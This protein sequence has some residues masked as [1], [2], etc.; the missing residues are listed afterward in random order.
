MA[1]PNSTLL[2]ALRSLDPPARHLFFFM[3]HSE[4][5]V[6]AWDGLGDRVI[7]GVTYKGIGNAASISGVSRSK[8]LQTETVTVSLNGVPLS[9]LQV[10]DPNI[11]DKPAHITARWFAEDGTE[12]AS[13]VVFKGFGNYLT[14]NFGA[15]SV[16]LVAHL[17]GQMADWQRAPQ[18]FYTSA[19][20][21][22]LFAG[23]TGFDRVKTLQNTVVSGWGKYKESTGGVAKFVG[24][25]GTRPYDS[26][27]LRAIG[28]DVGGAAL[29][30]TSL[31]LLTS[32]GTSTPALEAQVSGTDLARNNTSGTLQI[33]GVDCYVDID[34]DIRS[35]I[36]QI[37]IPSGGSVA[38]RLRVVTPIASIGTA[39]ATNLIDSGGNIGLL[40][41]NLTSQTANSADWKAKSVFCNSGGSLFNNAGTVTSIY[42]G[43]A[44]AAS[45]AVIEEISGA[46][47]TVVSGVVKCGGNNVF[48]S[49][50]G[51][52]L[53]SAG[54]RIYPSGGVVSRD[55]ARVWT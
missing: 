42:S 27:Q 9:A 30:T 18:S 6:A 47:V 40:G 11:R 17:R 5:D 45:H 38:N 29:Q 33:L 12:I 3:E 23:D 25:V 14:S 46:A 21:N 34:G 41:A 19:E 43:D 8:D 53:T 54:R 37:I 50:T 39:T 2:A 22:R 4:G 13:R 1:A 10:T 31:S 35:S 44:G 28:N 15:D 24:S 20:Q 16:T 26:L 36:G 32:L 55:F 52:V 49:D 7:S 51:V 48:I